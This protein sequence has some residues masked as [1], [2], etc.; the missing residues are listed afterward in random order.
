MR[1]SSRQDEILVG[2]YLM[3]SISQPVPAFAIYTINQ[4]VLVYRLCPFAE[5]IQSFWI[6]AN[7]RYIEKGSHHVCFHFSENGNGKNQGTFPTK[8]LF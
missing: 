6:I 3:F 1:F 7:I 8:S 2:G 4:D 5:M